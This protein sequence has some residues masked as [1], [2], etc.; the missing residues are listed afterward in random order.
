MC[1]YRYKYVSV[2]KYFIF[3]IIQFSVDLYPHRFTYMCMWLVSCVYIM[4]VCYGLSV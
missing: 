3:D 1:V 4:C 2:L